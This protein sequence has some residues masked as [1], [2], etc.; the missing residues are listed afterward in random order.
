MDNIERAI[1][2]NSQLEK[3]EKEL[4]RNRNETSL[5]QSGL[6]AFSR[7]VLEKVK[8]STAEGALSGNKE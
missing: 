7:D 3:I 8:P 2:R 1:A 4:V 6:E 5:L